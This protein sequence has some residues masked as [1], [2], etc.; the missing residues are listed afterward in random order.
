MYDNTHIIVHRRDEY[1]G[2]NTYTLDV[3]TRKWKPV[4]VGNQLKGIQVDFS[5]IVGVNLYLINNNNTI[6]AHNITNGHLT[7]MKKQ[8]VG[9]PAPVAETEPTAVVVVARCLFLVVMHNNRN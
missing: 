9:E 7:D 4:P 1:N 8:A 2:E 3:S 6:Y 5:F